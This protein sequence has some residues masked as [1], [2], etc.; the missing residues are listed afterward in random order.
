MAV[1]FLLDPSTVDDILK[2]NNSGDEKFFDHLMIL[3]PSAFT[4]LTTVAPSALTTLV[5]VAPS[6]FTNPLD[7]GT[8][9]CCK[10]PIFLKIR[11]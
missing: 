10:V 8:T 2:A 4:K 6:S 3:L 5:S 1:V 11:L 9:H 7:I